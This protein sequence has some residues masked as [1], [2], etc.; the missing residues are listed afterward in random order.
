MSYSISKMRTKISSLHISYAVYW[1][2]GPLIWVPRGVGVVVGGQLIGLGPLTVQSGWDRGPGVFFY[3]GW[4]F[5]AGEV[6]LAWRLI[7]WHALVL[8]SGQPYRAKGEDIG[9]ET[10]CGL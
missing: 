9:Q 3:S 6:G 5:L 4:T 10:C 1:D 7:A 2:P 8:T